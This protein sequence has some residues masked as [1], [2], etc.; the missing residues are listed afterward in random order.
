MEVERKIFDSTIN[1][2]WDEDSS[3]LIERLINKEKIVIL[4]EDEEGT[5]F[6][7]YI[8]KKVEENYRK[9]ITVKSN[10]SYLFNLTHLKIFE[11]K[12]NHY[13]YQLFDKYSEHLLCINEIYLTK[14]KYASLSFYFI[15]SNHF[16]FGKEQYPLSKKE[17]DS[18]KRV[19]FTPTNIWIYQLK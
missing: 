2:D 17:K 3:V 12:Q 14:K 9:R 8:P 10:E 19:S 6:G 18:N 1:D 15:L 13:S 5:K 16:N 11:S 4:I 7:V